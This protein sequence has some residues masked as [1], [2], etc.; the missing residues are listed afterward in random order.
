MNLDGIV[1]TDSNQDRKCT[2]NHHADLGSRK[3]HQT[4]GQYKACCN[5]DNREECIPD[6][7]KESQ[8]GYY[9]ENHRC[10]D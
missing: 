7:G 1:N 5:D 3:P 6:M 4:K 9:H 8:D 10:H 2:N